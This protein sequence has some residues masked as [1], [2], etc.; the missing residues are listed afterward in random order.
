MTSHDLPCPPMISHALPCPRPH[1]YAWEHTI[2]GKIMAIRKQELALVRSQRLLSAVLSIF[3]TT[4]A[5]A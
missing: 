2:G 1:R 3:M 5:S 4:Q